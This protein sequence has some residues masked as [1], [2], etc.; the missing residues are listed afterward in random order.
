VLRTPTLK[1]SIKGQLQQGCTHNQDLESFK[2]ED[3]VCL[4]W[5]LLIA[6]KI[7]MKM[8]QNRYCGAVQSW[9][10]LAI[11]AFSRCKTGQ[12][13]MCSGLFYIARLMRWSHGGKSSDCPVAKRLA[14]P[15]RTLVT[16]K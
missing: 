3:G 13:W 10:W 15:A 6:I 5:F 16:H 7:L 12:N 1:K 8:A 11:P 14:F 9:C 4:R 2:N